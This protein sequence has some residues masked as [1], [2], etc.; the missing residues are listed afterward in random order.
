MKYKVELP[1]HQE[2]QLDAQ[3][4]RLGLF[5]GYKGPRRNY[6]YRN[7]RFMGFQKKNC[8]FFHR[9]RFYLA[10]ERMKCQVNCDIFAPSLT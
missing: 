2:H 10:K 6:Y 9:L 1:F 7:V 5:T 3:I 8:W 4:Q